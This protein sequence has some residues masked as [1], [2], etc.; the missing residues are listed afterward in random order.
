MYFLVAHFM[1]GYRLLSLE[2]FGNQMVVFNACGAKWTGADDAQISW[3]V[4]H[5]PS[6]PE[7]PTENQRV[8]VV[9]HVWVYD[10][11]VVVDLF[12]PLLCNLSDIV[13]GGCRVYLFNSDTALS[14]LRA[15]F[16]W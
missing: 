16:S 3:I 10:L 9:L 5:N 4:R 15:S 14:T 13:T 6:Q 11:T 7:T 1:N 2:R 8:P 12:F